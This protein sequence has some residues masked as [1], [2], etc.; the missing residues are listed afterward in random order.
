LPGTVVVQLGG[1]LEYG[2]LIFSPG[3]FRL[4]PHGIHRNDENLIQNIHTRLRSF[5]SDQLYLK[6]CEDAAILC[7]DSI[8]KKRRGGGQGRGGG[9]KIG[10]AAA[11][12]VEAL[13]EAAEEVDNRKDDT[14]ED[15]TQYT[16]V[17]LSKI[18]LSIQ[19]ELLGEQLISYLIEWC[20][21]PSTMVPGCC[22]KDTTLLYDKEQGK[23][24]VHVPRSTNNNVF[25]RIP[26]PLIDPVC[27]DL[28]ARVFNFY[29]QTFWNNIDVFICCQAAQALAKRGCNIDRC[30]I[31]V[32]PGGVG[33]SLYSSHLA[34]IYGHNHAFF[35]PN[36][37]FAEDELRKQIEQ[38]AG[39]IILTGQEAPET[40]RK[41][42]EDLF[43]KTM[44]ADGMPGRKPYGITTRML[45]LIGWKRLEL[46]KL[47]TFAGVSERNFQSILRRSLVW[48]AKGRF[49]DAQFLEKHYP[50]SE[51][52]GIFPCDETLKRFLISRPAIAAAIRVQY[53]FESFHDRAACVSIIEDYVVRGLL[54]GKTFVVDTPGMN[55]LLY[56]QA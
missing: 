51:L 3:L 30:F 52:D 34:A 48:K 8:P 55:S 53:G 10:A 18:G 6:A 49:V 14:P 11:D 1:F 19:K 40:Y 7:V 44:S 22:Y 32:S 36:V 2:F 42:R 23:P 37:W 15:W 29:M 13:Q 33:Q 4:L 56:S 5:D 54:H 50:D 43:K 47:L 46:N 17:A 20:A 39:C 38:F 41:L 31:G 24:I 26:H 35:D 12:A 9:G 27:Q 28:Q 16:S 21:T 45:E 25:I